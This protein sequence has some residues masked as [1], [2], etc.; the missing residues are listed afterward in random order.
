ML[1]A[2]VWKEWREQRSL[3]ATGVALAVMLPLVLFVAATMALPSVT[4]QRVVDM[5]TLAF[6][7][8][9]WP[10]FVA[11]AGAGAFASEATGRTAGF[12]LSRPVSR[13]NVWLAKVGLAAGAALSIVVISLVIARLLQWFVGQPQI[14]DPL[15]SVLRGQAGPRHDIVLGA[16][17]L[18]SC[19]CAAAFLSAHVA[20]PLAAA[21]GGLV[22]TLALFVVLGLLAGGV[23]VV[24]AVQSM[25]VAAELTL[26]GTLLLVLSLRRFARGEALIGSRVRDTL[27]AVTLVLLITGATGFVPVLYVD[28]FG[29]L[30]RAVTRE[31][32]LSPDG[33]AAVVTAAPY[34]L[35]FGSLWRLPDQAGAEGGEGRGAMPQRL[36]RR[37]AFSPF[38]SDDGRWLY[39]FSAQRLLDRVRG[40][41]DLWRVRIDGTEEQLIME[42]VGEIVVIGSGWPHE[43]R[44]PSFSPDGSHISFSAGWWGA[45]PL[46]L[47]LERGTVER[48]AEWFD[49]DPDFPYEGVTPI[50]WTRSGQLLLRIRR[51]GED[52]RSEVRTVVS[53]DIDSGTSTDVVSYSR[54]ESGSALYGS[55]NHVGPL[56]PLQVHVGRWT[57][58][59][60]V[61]DPNY[62]LEVVGLPG[63]SVRHIES[64]PCGYPDFA[65]SADGTVVAYR[66]FTGC[67]EEEDGDL[68][69]I[70]PIFVVRNLSDGS[71]REIEWGAVLPDLSDGY[72]GISPG[73]DRASFFS[74]HRND[75]T[76]DFRIIDADGTTRRVDVR[77]PVGGALLD[78]L[79]TPR[80]L[81]EDRVVFSYASPHTNASS[82]TVRYLRFGAAVIMNVDDG[83][84]VHEFVIPPIDA[85]VY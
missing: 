17:T 41:V 53:Y 40:S 55:R 14:S 23:G 67:A 13:R 61:S 44:S 29:D 72:V 7:L 45:E 59:D 12:L 85:D 20:R 5:T 64:F 28:R 35:A 84:V 79:S 11:G 69:G 21:I 31:F 82:H 73:G 32:A 74:P 66:R 46:L 68:V 58:G 18:Y 34:P 6:I 77:H 24:V 2:L 52:G 83:S 47:D 80:W 54:P 62:E 56:M 65:V 81:G 39:Y 48:P 60:I 25:W 57:Q 16:S 3:L 75:R 38:F 30:D 42:S 1:K 22:T 63:G 76:A 49:L 19:F 8:M 9:L 70:D 33:S 10:I 15:W 71:T 37:L 27:G 51:Y 26:A 50:A 43:A 4:G 78:P 36:S